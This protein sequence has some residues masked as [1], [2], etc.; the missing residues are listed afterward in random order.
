MNHS[1]HFNTIP[2]IIGSDMKENVSEDDIMFTKVLAHQT[3]KFSFG[4][5]DIHDVL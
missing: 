2:C 4:C 3:L 1:V 5:T